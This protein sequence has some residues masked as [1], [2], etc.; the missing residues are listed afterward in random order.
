MS[1]RESIRLAL[2]PVFE[3]HKD[4]VFFAYLFGSSVSNETIPSSDIDIAVFLSTYSAPDSAFDLKLDLYADFCRALKRND[5]DVVVLNSAVNIILLDDIVRHGLVIF[6][7]NPEK[8]EL[9]E[10]EVIHSA[11]DFRG[12][13]QAVMGV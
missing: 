8:R 4:K 2:T 6:D 10:L 5:V 12:Q 13:R 7:R 9:F 1:L 11:L 3:K